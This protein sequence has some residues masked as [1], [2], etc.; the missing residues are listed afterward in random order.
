MVAF[1]IAVYIRITRRR[2]QNAM[3]RDTWR[4]AEKEAVQSH[5]NLNYRDHQSTVSSIFTTPSSPDDHQHQQ[6]QLPSSYRDAEGFHDVPPGS[7]DVEQAAGPNGND[8]DKANFVLDAQ[9]L[10]RMN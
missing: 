10:N 8:Q 4:E 7:V 5:R 6:Q 3:F 2:R 9:M 1:A